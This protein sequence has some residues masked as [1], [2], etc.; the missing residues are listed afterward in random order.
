[1][2][3][4]FYLLIAL[5]AIGCTQNFDSDNFLL[6]ESIENNAAIE[7]VKSFA[8]S[9]KGNQIEARSAIQSNMIIT[10]IESKTL[11][12]DISEDLRSQRSNI[13]SKSVSVQL[14]TVKF[15]RNGKSGFSIVSDD[16]RTNR[17][18]AYVENGSLSDTTF[19]IGLTIALEKI[20]RAC[21]YDLVDYYKNEKFVP[22]RA[23][24]PLLVNNILPTYWDQTAP[25]NL[26][27]PPTSC[28]RPNEWAYAGRA[29]AGC[30]PVAVS[31]AVAFLCPPAIS[32]NFDLLTLRQSNFQSG[33][34]SGPNIG[35][36]STFIGYIG[37]CVNASYG[38]NT[39]AWS[40]EIRD[41][42]SSWGIFYQFYSNTNIDLGK[43]AQNL[44][45]HLPH[46]TSGFRKSPREGHTW[47]WTGIHCWCSGIKSNGEYIVYP[48]TVL[49]Y[50]NWGWGGSSDGWFVEYERPD[51]N[52]P[53]FLDDNDQLYITGTSYVRP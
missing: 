39:G 52:K 44:N 48:G 10:E 8:E 42:F 49:L 23:D 29:A 34:I 9:I 30:T 5:I 24:F 41:E 45:Y 31:Q 14:K 17:V 50:C 40:K 38:C 51:P 37:Y 18:Y 13:D 1:M 33:S 25:F 53:S 12:F 21:E 6:S 19:N 22:T 27:A 35:N 7:L 4:T 47:L 46:I 15:N 2:K 28:S 16:S 3:K 11:Y 32:Q 43:L 20:E 36:L 26:S